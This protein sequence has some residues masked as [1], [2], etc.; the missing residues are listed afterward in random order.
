MDIYE[1]EKLRIE[2]EGWNSKKAL[3][4]NNHPLNMDYPPNIWENIP[5]ELSKNNKTGYMNITTLNGKTYYFKKSKYATDIS[6]I[7]DSPVIAAYNY[8]LW[9]IEKEKIKKKKQKMLELYPNKR[10][11][12]CPFEEYFLISIVFRPSLNNS[13]VN[14]FLRKI[15]GIKCICWRIIK[16]VLISAVLTKSWELQRSS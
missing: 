14:N 1:K 2:K 8:S 15:L 6:D 11:L 7:Y 9:K 12:Y 5:L 3:N 16:P 10:Y 4:K 13:K